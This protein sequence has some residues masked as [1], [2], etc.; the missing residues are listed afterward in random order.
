MMMN[1][2]FYKTNLVLHKVN[3]CAVVLYS[4][5]IKIQTLVGTIE[6]KIYNDVGS[7][8]PDK[9]L[10]L[11]DVQLVHIERY[12]VTSQLSSKRIQYCQEMQSI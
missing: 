8:S 5:H 9:L 6:S 1:F 10:L 4:I 2:S 11:L 7:H 3:Y 12:K